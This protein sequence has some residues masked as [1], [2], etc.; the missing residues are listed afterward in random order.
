MRTFVNFYSTF[1]LIARTVLLPRYYDAHNMTQR[2]PSVLLCNVQICLSL[3][4][5]YNY[6]DNNI[7]II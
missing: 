3:M 6:N 1:I 7:I 2:V 5:L 4:N